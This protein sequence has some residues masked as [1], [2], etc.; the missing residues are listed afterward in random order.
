MRF[1]QTL[2]NTAKRTFTAMCAVVL[3]VTSG[4]IT[5]DMITMTASAAPGGGTT[6]L[7]DALYASSGK[8]YKESQEDWQSYL[9]SYS[10]SGNTYYLGTPYSSWLHAASPNGD[11]WQLDE[12]YSTQITKNGG[13][14][15]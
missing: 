6:Y 12:G 1:L 9:D 5:S 4:I 15:T 14:T 10:K 3:A 7:S 2:K 13:S 11:K 8:K